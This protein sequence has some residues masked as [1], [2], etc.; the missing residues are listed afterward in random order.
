[1]SIITVILHI[2]CRILEEMECRN[3]CEVLHL[4]INESYYY[5]QHYYFLQISNISLCVFVLIFSHVQIL[6]QNV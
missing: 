1:M 2:L 3:S 4:L 5:Y 6:F